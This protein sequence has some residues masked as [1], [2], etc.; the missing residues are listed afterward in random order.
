M[1]NLFL[2]HFELKILYKTKIQ[3]REKSLYWNNCERL[4][5][6][7]CLKAMFSCHARYLYFWLDSEGFYTWRSVNATKSWPPKS[8]DWT[9][10]DARPSWCATV[11]WSRSAIE[12]CDRSMDPDRSPRSRHRDAV[13]SSYNSD[14]F[15]FC[16]T[17]GSMTLMYSKVDRT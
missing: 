1:S 7:F 9:L 3:R 14:S 8:S 6:L 12:H 11:I 13:S 2:R 10:P 16:E 5:R 17:W 15:R 4:K